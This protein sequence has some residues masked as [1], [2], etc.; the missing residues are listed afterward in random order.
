MVDKTRGRKYSGNYS[1]QR[2]LP[3]Q[4]GFIGDRI[5][6]SCCK[7]G[8][9]YAKEQDNEHQVRLKSIQM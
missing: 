3:P 7:Q 8:I 9:R 5:I 2:L 1:N 6:S 4:L